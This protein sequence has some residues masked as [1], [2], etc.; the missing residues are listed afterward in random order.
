MANEILIKV[1]EFNRPTIREELEALALQDFK[2][3][4]SGFEGANL[5]RLAPFSEATRV[6]TRRRLQDGTV[7][8]DVAARGEVRIETSNTLTPGELTSLNGVLDGH[9]ATVD[10]SS[11]AKRRQTKVDV[12]VLRATF[13][14]GIADPTMAKVVRLVLIDNGEDV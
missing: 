7:Q 1:K 14:G 5:D 8:E 9:D 4:F 10:H 2:A 6:I 12:A 3:S 13:D 11:Q